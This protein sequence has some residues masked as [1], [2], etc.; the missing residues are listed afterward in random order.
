MIRAKNKRINT[1]KQMPARSKTLPIDQYARITI[2]FSVLVIALALI[3]Y[4]ALTSLT[5]WNT[6]K[7]S[8]N[9]KILAVKTSLISD[10]ETK[11]ASI[12]GTITE[13]LA[14]SKGFEESGNVKYISAK[15]LSQA[16]LNESQ[17]EI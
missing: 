13:T 4:V 15:P 17:R 8:E 7:R 10:L 6:A 9:E 16:T 12:D 14:H 3:G 11:L 1:V 5:V 2:P